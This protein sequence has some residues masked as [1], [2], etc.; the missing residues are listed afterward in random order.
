MSFMKY[1]AEGHFA[2][3]LERTAER[4]RAEAKAFKLPPAGLS[5]DGQRML[6]RTRVAPGEHGQGLQMALRRPRMG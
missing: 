3:D 2:K 6:S 4:V 1:V 5:K